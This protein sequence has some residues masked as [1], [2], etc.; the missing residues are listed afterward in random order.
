MLSKKKKK[1]SFLWFT[2]PYPTGKEV[3]GLKLFP[4]LYFIFRGY[5][6]SFFSSEFTD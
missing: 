1:A 6:K 3:T 5:I 4:L 2:D